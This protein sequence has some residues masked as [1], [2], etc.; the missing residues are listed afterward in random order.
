[1]PDSDPMT[2]FH[3]PQFDFVITN[4][5]FGFPLAG[6]IISIHSIVY[7]YWP[8]Y[9]TSLLPRHSVFGTLGRIYTAVHFSYALQ[10]CWCLLLQ[11]MEVILVNTRY[12]WLVL[13]EMLCDDGRRSTRKRILKQHANRQ[14]L[15]PE[16]LRN[17]YIQLE[18]LH[19]HFLHFNGAII[20]PI[21]AIVINLVLF[22]NFSLIRYWENLN[23]VLIGI[24]TIWSL[25]SAVCLVLAYGFFGN[26]HKLNLLVLRSMA[27]KV[28]GWGSK[29]KNVQM[30]KFIK[31]RKPLIYGYGKLYV[32]R[33]ISVL[34]FLKMVSVGTCKLLVGS[35]KK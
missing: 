10:G 24:L 4:L 21:Y 1:M 15:Q 12:M 30:K 16:N 29:E 11:M 14:F 8:V 31:S 7:P 2:S 22:C 5:G 28:G 26:V 23:I 18:I 27:H 6:F 3:N 19:A 9:Y 25:N 20:V 35:K 13:T 17:T 34:N 32:I 33:R